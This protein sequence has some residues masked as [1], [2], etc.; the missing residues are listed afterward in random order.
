MNTRC[1]T[2]T[3]PSANVTNAVRQCYT[4]LLANEILIN[5][6]KNIKGRHFHFEAHNQV[7]F[8]TSVVFSMLLS[9]VYL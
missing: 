1:K 2:I 7:V 5:Q 6:T 9:F 8:R 3:M 4:E